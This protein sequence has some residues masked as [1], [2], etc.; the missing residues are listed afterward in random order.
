MSNKYFCEVKRWWLYTQFNGRWRKA[1]FFW[2]FTIYETAYCHP[3]LE[4]GTQYLA[5][6]CSLLEKNK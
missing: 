4:N 1:V 2:R 3:T 5:C 6:N